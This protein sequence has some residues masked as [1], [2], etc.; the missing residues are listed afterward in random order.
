VGEYI[1]TKFWIGGDV[2]RPLASRLCDAIIREEIFVDD[3]YCKEEQWL[4]EGPVDLLAHRVDG[5][6]A[7]FEYEKN[8][9]DCRVL[10]EFCTEK[11]I[12]WDKWH[13]GGM[14]GELSPAHYWWRPGMES[15]ECLLC[16]HD[17][18][19][20]IEKQPIDAIIELIDDTAL[21]IFV[22]DSKR[23]K[24]RILR[25]LRLACPTVPNLPPF[26]VI[27]DEGESEEDVQLAKAVNILHEAADVV[28]AMDPQAR[29]A[30]RDLAKRLEPKEEE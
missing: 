23:L 19:L 16:T 7:L 20:L 26:R 22:S 11:L 3:D 25:K 5:I 13:T 24:E 18:D 4:P 8:Y 29:D 28:S 27:N 14:G 10:E 1:H 15:E 30:I 21:T 9:G 12:P 17:Q 2:R 6:I